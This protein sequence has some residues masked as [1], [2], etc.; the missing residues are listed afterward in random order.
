MKVKFNDSEEK[1]ITE[2]EFENLADEL[3]NSGWYIS[4]ISY[5]FPSYDDLNNTMNSSFSESVTI[6]ENT[7]E[8]RGIKLN[9]PYSADGWGVDIDYDK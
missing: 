3:I 6:V 1:E 2:E 7:K 8:Y 9:L 5:S 4:N